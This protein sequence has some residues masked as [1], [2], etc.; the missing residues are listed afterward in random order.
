MAQLDEIGK[1]S[2]INH[3][4]QKFIITQGWEKAVD[5]ALEDGVLTV[6]EEQTLVKSAQGLSLTQQDLDTNGAYSR[7]AKAAV[8]RELLEGK[9]PQRVTV[10]G[11]VPFNFQK[12][13][14]LL[15]LFPGATYLEQRMRTQYEG[16][17]QG[18]S[19][20]V[21]RGLYYRT[22]GFRGRPVSTAEMV[23][24]G[25]GSFGITER[26]MYFSGPSKAFRVR[27]DKIVSFTAYSD[28]IGFQRDAQTAKPQVFITGDGWFTY[29]LV[30]NLAKRL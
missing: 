1:D 30:V 25:Q 29:N 3:I 2:F 11:E 18:V 4:E 7:V 26:H 28:G 22:G 14:N 6:D 21:A 9:L 23:N 16:S 10:V 8:I 27:Y 13:E 15:W 24:L 17:Y 19:V 12:G 5:A 20:R